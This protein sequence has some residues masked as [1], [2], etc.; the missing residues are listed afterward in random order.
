MTRH[1]EFID[2]IHSRAARIAIGPSTLR[3]QGD[4]GLSD[5]ARE[6]LVALDLRR[7]AV[8]RAQVFDCALDQATGEL[9]RVLRRFRGR[10][11]AARKAINI[12]L[13]EC[14]YTVYLRKEYNLDR[15][16]H[17]YELPL[18]SI[19]ARHLRLEFQEKGRLCAWPGV[20]GLTPNVSSQYQEAAL[21]SA[22]MR[23]IARVHLD[24]YWW[25]QSRDRGA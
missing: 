4:Q 5:A 2:A 13:C 25:S 21:W 8:R 12:F 11:G 18:D 24:A 6:F 10:W 7:F 15:A 16:E 9:V 14:L 23:N 3:G 1:H 19:T 22:E 17:F 20:K